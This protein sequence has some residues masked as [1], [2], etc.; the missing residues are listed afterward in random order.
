MIISCPSCGASFNVQPE[1]LGPTG[2]TVKCSKCAHRWRVLPDGTAEEEPASELP[3]APSPTVSAPA[4]RAEPSDAAL[5]PADPDEPAGEPAA[6][7]S[8]GRASEF[9]QLE[10]NMMAFA[11]SQAQRQGQAPPFQINVQ[12]DGET[13]ARASHGANRDAAARAFSP[14]P[15]S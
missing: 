5:G 12:V 7:D 15:A 14:V 13:V 8:A 6:A 1:A 11:N 2:R 9:A 4:L 10:A 3:A